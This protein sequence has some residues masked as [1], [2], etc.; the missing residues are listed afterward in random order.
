MV[1]L[2]LR[3]YVARRARNEAR[4]G[5][6]AQP[7]QWMTASFG[8]RKRGEHS[9]VALLVRRQCEF[10]EHVADV[11]FHR[12]P[13]T[14]NSSAIAAFDRPSAIKASTSRSR[15]E[16]VASSLGEHQH[17]QPRVFGADP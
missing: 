7:E 9:P 10:G 2:A 5:H 4:L 12:A 15:A 16:R 1:N 11:L 13:M 3:E 8:E 17:R 6:F 14:V